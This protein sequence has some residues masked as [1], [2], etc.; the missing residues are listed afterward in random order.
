[1]TTETAP[2]V[3]PTIIITEAEAEILT[4]LAMTAE[5]SAPLASEML[6]EELERAESCEPDELPAD[7][8]TMGS[9]VEFVDEGTGA[10]HSVRLVYPREA[11]SEAGKISI[12]TPLGAGLIGLRT[13]QSISWPNRSGQHRQLRIVSVSQPAPDG[14]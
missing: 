10:T 12:L 2:R 13:G 11:D 8:V 7:A 14:R 3:R 6:L 9:D 1:M 4:N 5:Q